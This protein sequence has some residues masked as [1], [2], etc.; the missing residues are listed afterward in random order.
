VDRSSVI[1]EL[2]PIASNFRSRQSLA[3]YFTEHQIIGIEDI[4]TRALTKHLRTAGAMRS[5]LT[6]ELTEAEAIQ[7][8]KD[9]TPMAGSDFVQEVNAPTRF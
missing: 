6:T 7:A 2:S 4:D 1:G 3:E 8:A 5:C 9:S